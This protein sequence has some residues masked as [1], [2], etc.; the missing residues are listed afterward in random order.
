MNTVNIILMCVLIA[1][2]SAIFGYNVG[3]F[4][5]RKE[6]V[7][8]IKSLTDEIQKLATVSDKMKKS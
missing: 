1:M 3:K 6:A 4:A 5:G 8:G 2:I 7:S